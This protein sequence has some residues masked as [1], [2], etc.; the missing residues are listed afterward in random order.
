MIR[1]RAFTKRFGRLTAVDALTLDIHQGEAVAL[2]GPNGSG[3]TTTLKAAAGLITPTCGEVLLGDE[4]AAASL[5]EARRACS[6]LPQKAAFPE[7]LTGREVLEFYRRLRDVAPARTSEALRF[8]SLN[9]AGTQ[10][11][12]AYSGGM[13][14]RLGLAVAILPDT[15]ALLLDE[16]TAALDPDGLCAFYGLVDRRRS[17]GKTVFF[18]SHQLG[19]AERLAD[20]LAVLVDGR[21]IALFTQA[22]LAD[23]LANRGVMRLRFSRCSNS[24]LPAVRRLSPGATW[25]GAEL[26]VPGPAAL[27]PAVLDAV[28]AEGCEIRD[29]T[30]EDERLDTLYRELVGAARS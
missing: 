22:E 29:L 19:D 17:Q 18:T 24:V 15:P 23:R 14:Q 25:S 1:F 30:A 12:G 4:G 27:R 9:G 11:V 20:R 13:I 16:P 26:I 3:K 8:A 7:A 2:L 5:P 21:L 6:F 10:L 28:R